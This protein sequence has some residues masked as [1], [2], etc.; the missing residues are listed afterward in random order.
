[1][2]ND[3]DFIH[4]TEIANIF[5]PL[6]FFPLC[7]ITTALYFHWAIKQDK[8]SSCLTEAVLTYD[9]RYHS[10]FS[11]LWIVF[12]VI[13]VTVAAHSCF[14]KSFGNI[15]IPPLAAQ[16]HNVCPYKIFNCIDVKGVIIICV[17]VLV[18]GVLVTVFLCK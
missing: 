11:V 9:W 10:S 7:H 1:M 12:R 17:S 5:V 14:S 16:W 18:F 8:L 15:I 2:N 13:R 3:L 6:T 4:L